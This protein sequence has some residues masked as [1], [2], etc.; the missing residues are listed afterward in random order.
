MYAQWRQTERESAVETE[1]ARNYLRQHVHASRFVVWFSQAKEA[2]M[3]RTS[4][5]FIKI[6]SDEE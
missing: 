6:N 4:I 2:V 1:S 5:L 3:D